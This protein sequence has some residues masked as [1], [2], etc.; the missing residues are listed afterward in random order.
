L[1]DLEKF[2]ILESV[3]LTMFEKESTGPRLEASVPR[4][5]AWAS[6]APG[7]GGG[8]LRF[9]PQKEITSSGRGCNWASKRLRVVNEVTLGQIFNSKYG[10]GATDMVTHQKTEVGRKQTG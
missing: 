8:R 2:V 1:L 4:L 9:A 6:T 7:G 10:S 5:E 3:I